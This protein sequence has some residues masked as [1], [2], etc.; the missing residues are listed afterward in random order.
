MGHIMSVD[1]RGIT[2][3]SE[4]T[5]SAGLGAMTSKTDLGRPFYEAPATAGKAGMGN[6]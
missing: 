4:A 2:G 3:L 1:E 6:A 5:K